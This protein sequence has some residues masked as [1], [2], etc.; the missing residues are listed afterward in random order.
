ME[1]GGKKGKSISM[2]YGPYDNKMEMRNEVNVLGVCP[3][4][5]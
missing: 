1:M 5:N 4:I 2:F 3:V